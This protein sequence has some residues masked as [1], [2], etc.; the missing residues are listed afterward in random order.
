M[1]CRIQ[2][3]LGTVSSSKQTM[4]TQ[5]PIDCQLNLRGPRQGCPHLGPQVGQ[6]SSPEEPL[7]QVPHPRRLSRLMHDNYSYFFLFGPMH[8][9]TIIQVKLMLEDIGITA[10]YTASILKGRR[11]CRVCLPIH[12]SQQL[13]DDIIQ[14]IKVKVRS[15]Y[16]W[17]FMQV[18][19]KPISRPVIHTSNR[20][21]VLT[22]VA[23]EPV[24]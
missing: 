20:F 17:R 12:M 11:Y 14:D 21:A 6:T 18:T 16:K 4:D 1:V 13:D 9:F 24:G 7:F 8:C 19:H 22:E 23:D 15:A 3:V 2:L 10:F 5:N